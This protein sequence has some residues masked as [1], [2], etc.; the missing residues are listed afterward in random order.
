[1][2]E[3]NLRRTPAQIRA[4]ILGQEPAPEGW[5]ELIEEAILWGGGDNT[6]LDKELAVDA[7]YFLE[8][9]FPGEEWG[10]Q[11]FDRLLSERLNWYWDSREELGL[12]RASEIVE[13]TEDLAAGNPVGQVGPLRLSR[14]KADSMSEAELVAFALTEPGMY[15]M[16][17]VRQP[18]KVVVFYGVRSI[19]DVRR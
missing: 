3:K 17:S 18:G 5:N 1:M 16:D 13:D 12:T 15:V 19:E 4:M 6:G 10:W 14:A 2:S 9:T 11:D 7:T 8:R